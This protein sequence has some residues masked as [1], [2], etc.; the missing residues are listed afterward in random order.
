M[1]GVKSRDR[2]G[3]ARPC[4]AG[5]TEKATDVRVT[6]E[7]GHLTGHT[8]GRGSPQVAC[9]SWILSVATWLFH[10]NTTSQSTFLQCLLRLC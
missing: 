4:G 6:L 5:C 10:V 8:G 7:W 1:V 9:A 3:G 2:G